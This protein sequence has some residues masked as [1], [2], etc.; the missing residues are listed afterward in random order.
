MHDCNGRR[1]TGRCIGWWLQEWWTPLALVC[2]GHS[3]MNSHPRMPRIVAK[4][5][6]GVCYLRHLCH[7]L[8]RNLQ[9]G[10]PKVHSSSWSSSPKR[11][12]TGRTLLP[13][14]PVWYYESLHT[15]VGQSKPFCAKAQAPV[16]QKQQLC[17]KSFSNQS[18]IRHFEIFGR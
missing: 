18:K 1:R 4:I 6:K 12:Q 16:Q 5:A 2:T 3:E 8:G 17:I 14:F 11:K 15:H 13:T 9:E 10:K 7:S